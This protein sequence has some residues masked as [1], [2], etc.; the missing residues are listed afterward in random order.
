MPFELVYYMHTDVI[1]SFASE[2]ILKNQ[3]VYKELT[4]AAISSCSCRMAWK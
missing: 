2:S 4:G 1:K 3:Y